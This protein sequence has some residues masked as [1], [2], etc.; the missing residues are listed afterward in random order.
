MLVVT[1]S[2]RDLI[3]TTFSLSQGTDEGGCYAETCAAISVVMIAQRMLQINTI[4]SLTCRLYNNHIQYDLSHKYGDVMESCLTMLFSQQCL[5]IV[6]SSHTS[7]TWHQAR[8]THP[9]DV[10]GLLCVAVRKM[11]SSF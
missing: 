3:K 9:K 2:G 5:S 11:S 8:R 6:G 1:S 7:I 10:I 4:S